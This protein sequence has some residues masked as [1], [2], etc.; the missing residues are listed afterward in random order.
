MRQLGSAN[1]I[2]RFSQEHKSEV[3]SVKLT[4]NS[5]RSFPGR[6]SSITRMTSSCF[7]PSPSNSLLA[8][9]IQVTPVSLLPS[10]CCWTSKTL[11]D[12]ASKTLKT[13][14]YSVDVVGKY[15]TTLNVISA[16]TTPLIKFGMDTGEVEEDVSSVRGTALEV[17][18]AAKEIRAVERAKNGGIDD[19]LMH[20]TFIRFFLQLLMIIL[21]VRIQYHNG[22]KKDE[23]DQEPHVRCVK[24]SQAIP[25]LSLRSLS[26]ISNIDGASVSQLTLVSV[27]APTMTWLFGR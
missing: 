16:D 26:K 14:K 25:I 13:V 3:V 6:R 20:Y 7:S 8:V 22:E 2:V 23:R 11:K 1:Q 5:H 4:M 9:G 17:D 21:L 27:A 19:C 15:D 12:I 24:I 10:L 18:C